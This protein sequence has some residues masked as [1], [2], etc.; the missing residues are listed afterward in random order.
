MQGSVAGRRWRQTAAGGNPS[1]HADKHMAQII[2]F[3]KCLHRVKLSLKLHMSQCW[4][5]VF[6]LFFFKIRLSLWFAWYCLV[7]R[8]HGEWVAARHCCEAYLKCPVRVK[9]GARTRLSVKLQRSVSAVQRCSRKCQDLVSAQSRWSYWQQVSAFLFSFFFLQKRSERIQINELLY[10]CTILPLISGCTQGELP[11]RSRRCLAEMLIKKELFSQPQYE[12]CTQKIRVPFMEYQTLSV[13]SGTIGWEVTLPDCAVHKT[14]HCVAF[15]VV[16]FKVD[17][18][19]HFIC[20]FCFKNL[21]K[22]RHNFCFSLVLKKALR[23]ITKNLFTVN[24]HS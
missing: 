13:V 6:C 10:I 20:I 7:S 4:C 16:A 11:C 3:S 15:S 5:I 2:H 9:E 18:E 12:N 1:L 23:R 24:K 14:T 21:P 17:T 22:W 8:P 19:N